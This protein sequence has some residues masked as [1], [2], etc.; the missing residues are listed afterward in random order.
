MA[1]PSS[2]FMVGRPVKGPDNNNNDRGFSG[3]FEIDLLIM[4]MG[5]RNGQR[6]P[7]PLIDYDIDYYDQA[8][9]LIRKDNDMQRILYLLYI[10]G[11]RLLTLGISD[12][13]LDLRPFSLVHK[14]GPKKVHL[15]YTQV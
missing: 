14:L 1:V 13:C 10:M 12:S 15:R 11:L 5:V 4:G 8:N 3:V 6:D 7:K 2:C 9:L